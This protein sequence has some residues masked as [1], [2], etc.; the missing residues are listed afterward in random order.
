MTT[1]TANTTPIYV[2]A[3]RS[4]GVKLTTGSST[5]TG[6]SATQLYVAGSD[7]GRVER[8]RAMPVA[9]GS[10]SKLLVYR[11]Q[12]SAGAFHLLHDWPLGS[13]TLS[14][15]GTAGNVDIPLGLNLSAGDEIWVQLT[16]AASW[17]VTLF[18]GNF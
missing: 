14:D 6:A 10:A 2:A 3:P 17:D 12:G 9:N 7:G 8:I 16:V 1:P 13:T 4:P 11:R 15:T 18:G 5:Y